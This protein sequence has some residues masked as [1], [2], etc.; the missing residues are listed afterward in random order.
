[1]RGA[2][3]GVLAH[4]RPGVSFHG[5]TLKPAEARQVQLLIEKAL[6]PIV[7]EEGKEPRYDL[8]NKDY[9]KSKEDYR[10]QARALALWLGFPCFRFQAGIEAKVQTPPPKVPEGPELI[11]AWIESRQLEDDTLEALF[12][13]LMRSEVESYLGFTSGNSSPKS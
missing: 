7:R 8:E 4:S 12:Q 9:L 1:L 6:P 13:S 5:P 10:R 3:A 11:A 2:V